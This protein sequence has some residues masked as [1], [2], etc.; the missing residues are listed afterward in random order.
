MC[1]PVGGSREGTCPG[2]HIGRPR[3]SRLKSPSTL[4]E[5][6]G[7]EP[8]PYRATRSAKQRADVGIGPYEKEGAPAAAA[9]ASGA[10]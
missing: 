10:E 5:R 6:A 8:R 2:R 1:P 7:T 9:R 3:Q 4:E